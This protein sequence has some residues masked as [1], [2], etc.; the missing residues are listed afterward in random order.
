MEK[1]EF[2]I[3]RSGYS[4][5]MDLAR[6]QK[7]SILIPTPGQTEQLYLAKNLSTKNFALCIDQNDFSLIDAIAKAETFSYQPLPQYDDALLKQA[8]KS[9]VKKL[10]TKIDQSI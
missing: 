6:L 7:K 2:V 8:I 5:I 9:L 3:S 1:A 4:T 10:E